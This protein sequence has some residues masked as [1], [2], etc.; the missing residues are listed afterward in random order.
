VALADV[1]DALTST[2]VYKSVLEPIVARSMIE[3]E[4]AK[5]FDPA[6]VNAFRMSWDDFLN[7]QGLTYDG[8]PELVES[9]VS[10]NV[11]R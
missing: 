3:Q 1:Y 6:I 8:N 10:D 4:E 2:R 7:V 5:H 11:R 9:P